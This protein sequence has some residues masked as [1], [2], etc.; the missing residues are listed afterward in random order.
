MVVTNSLDCRKDSKSYF[1]RV[2][3]NFETLIINRGKDSGIV[4]MSIEECNSLFTTNYEL[5]NIINESRLDAAI[6]KWKKGN[7]FSKDLIEE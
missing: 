2:S 1:H 3:K 5:S 7:I 4:L 6:D